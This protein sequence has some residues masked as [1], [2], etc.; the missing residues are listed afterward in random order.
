MLFHQIFTFSVSSKSYSM[1]RWTYFHNVTHAGSN[2]R[3]GLIPFPSQF[4]WFSAP[5]DGGLGFNRFIVPKNLLHFR[6]FRI[7]HL[8]GHGIMETRVWMLLR[9]VFILFVCVCVYVCISVWMYTCMSKYFLP[10]VYLRS[11]LSAHPKIIPHPWAQYFSLILVCRSKTENLKQ[12]FLGRF[13]Y[14]SDISLHKFMFSCIYPAS[15]AWFFFVPLFPCHFLG[16]QNSVDY[17]PKVDIRGKQN[18]ERISLTYCSNGEPEYYFFE[19]YHSCTLRYK[20]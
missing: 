14:G 3:D 1:P 15:D 20:R 11:H 8:T 10:R 9:F 6:W 5:W 12:P 19:D 17:Q 16:I 2:L 13:F 7:S 18:V 4:V